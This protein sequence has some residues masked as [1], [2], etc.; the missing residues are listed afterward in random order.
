MSTLTVVMKKA[1]AAKTMVVKGENASFP[2]STLPPVIV[3]L[4]TA[5]AAKIVDARNMDCVSRGCNV[6]QLAESVNHTTIV[7]S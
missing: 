7:A 5:N 1:I 2:V 6:R 3:V 4:T